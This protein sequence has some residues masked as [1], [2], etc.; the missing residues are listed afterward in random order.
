MEPRNGQNLWAVKQKRSYIIL[1][2]FQVDNSQKE[3][4]E[5]LWN[6]DAST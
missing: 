4:L 2:R 3:P 1:S 5:E 6:L